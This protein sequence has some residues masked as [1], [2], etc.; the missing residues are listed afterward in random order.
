M[1]SYHAILGIE[2]SKR[3]EVTMKIINIKFNFKLFIAMLI[4]IIIILSS[5]FL[6]NLFKNS[7]ITMTN[8]NYTTI[9]KD[10]HNNINDYIGKKIIVSGYVFRAADF[11]DKQFVTARDMIV[12][13]SD[14]RIV[15]FLCEYDG[16]NEFENNSWIEVRGIIKL[17]DYHGPMPVIEVSEI[18]KIT[19]PNETFVFPPSSSSKGVKRDVLK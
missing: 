13:E 5:L 10:V 2:F 15:G 14:Y 7:C 1:L 6:M 11:S 17:K 4:S 8:E 18:K 19:T 9:L 16:I 12:T 3:M